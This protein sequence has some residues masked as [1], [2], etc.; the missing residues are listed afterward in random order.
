MVHAARNPVRIGA[1]ALVALALPASGLAQSASVAPHPPLVDGE[2]WVAFQRPTYER[3]NAHAITLVRPDGTDAF[4]AGAAIPGGE[5]L[6][7]DWSPD[8]TRIVLDA[9]N[10]HGTYDIWILSTSDW[11]AERA[12]ACD[13]PCLW[14]Q[15]PA[16]SPQGDRIA[17]Q[18]H[19]MTD[20]GEI[21]TIEILDLASG[22][23]TTLLETP[24]T[25][26]VYA[27]RWSPDGQSLVFEQTLVENDAFMG[28]SLEVLD[29]V[30]PGTT[31]RLIPV[32]TFANNADWSPDGTLIAFSAPAEGGEPGGPLSDIWVVAPD[33]TGLRRVTDA[34]SGGGTAVQPTFA[35]GGAR[36]TFKLGDAAL[37][38]SDAMA[39]I[40]LDGTDLKPLV[41]DGW[42]YG[43]HARLRPIP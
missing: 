14:A 31:R 9:A 22:A 7:P 33:G 43:Y 19:T 25:E 26:G 35:D 15:E 4:F 3:N 18:R 24:T 13:A 17:F 21:S 2:A 42:T 11:S 40:A 30:T 36:L 27:P 37:D 32:E 8:G 5:Q 10:L 20:A 29:L 41:G 1:L 16:W 12:V 34:A 39:S 6:H 28:V 38:A 23:L